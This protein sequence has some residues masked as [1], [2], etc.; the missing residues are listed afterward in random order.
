[1]LAGCSRPP[2]RSDFPS[3]LVPL[4]GGGLQLTTRRSAADA[5]RWAALI[6]NKE[7]QKL[8]RVGGLFSFLM[9]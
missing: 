5:G 3:S 9:R 1:V 7:C 4:A 6:A 2:Y 8:V